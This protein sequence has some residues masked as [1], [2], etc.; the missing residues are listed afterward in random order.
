MMYSR[1][2]TNSEGTP[3]DCA[4]LPETSTGP[5]PHKMEA[6][7]K[8]KVPHIKRAAVAHMLEKG[9]DRGV[10]EHMNVLPRLTNL[11]CCLKPRSLHCR[12][13]PTRLSCAGEANFTTLT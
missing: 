13:L 7:S 4:P 1:A 6:E 3:L 9:L 10:C 8:H 5:C 2:S 11:R 12:T